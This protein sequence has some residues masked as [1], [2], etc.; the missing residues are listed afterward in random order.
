[1]PNIAST[2]TGAR[3]LH[4]GHTAL[5]YADRSLT[6]ADLDDAVRRFASALLS[7]DLRPGDRVAVF[8]KNCPE[9]VITM[10]GVFAAGMVVVPVN[11]KLAGPE[12]AVVLE[13]SGARLLVHDTASAALVA[14]AADAGVR[15][16]EIG[17]AFDRFLAGG[18]ADQPVADV[19]DDA[20]A[21]LFYTSGT[22]GR[23]KGAMLTHRNLTAMTW[24]ELADVCDYRADDVALHV[25]PLSHGGGLYLLGAIARGSTNL[26]YSGSSFVPGEVLRL[27]ERERVTV[28]A[29]LAPTMIVMLLEADAETGADTSSLRRAVYGG[30]PMHLDSARR[31]VDRFGAVFVQI[32]GQGESP[33]TITYLDLSEGPV[34]DDRLISAGVPH[35]G[36]QVAVLDPDDRPLPLGA[37]GEICV[38]GD[39]VMS[40]Y[41]GNPAATETTLRNGWLHTGD[42]GRFDEHGRLTL[43][44]RS[45]DV[46]ISGGTNIYPRE[47]EDALLLHAGVREV[48]VFGEPDDVWGES[49]TA[50]VVREDGADVPAD[51]LI[52]WCRTR[53]AGFKK[54][55]RVV[56][57]DEL[58]TNAYG[59]V[60]RREVRD[61]LTRTSSA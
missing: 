60:L 37:T 23:P 48:V 16:L 54:P 34:D 55:K 25:T 5:R 19:P 52:D 39:T 36:V 15:T 57:L 47:V 31:M 11:A 1:M 20:V 17:A 6:Y 4:A 50:A 3:R 51:E 61:R 49:V 22:T 59:K 8:A 2:L 10:Y 18:S 35:P 30:A 27:I 53:I 32:Y 29:F 41:L 21:W 7:S 28:I 43:L 44:D 40:G 58:P 42:V 38:R 45:K 33:M 24:L 26:I 9:Y 12:L 56:F 46:I 14:G 13:D